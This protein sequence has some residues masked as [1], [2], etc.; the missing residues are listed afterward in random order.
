MQFSNG[1]SNPAGL[2]LGHLMFDSI[3]ATVAA[4]ILVIVFAATSTLFHGLGF[5]VSSL[6]EYAKRETMLMSP[7]WFIMVLYGFTGTL[8][9]Y[10]FSVVITSPLAAGVIR[11]P[12]PGC[13]CWS[14]WGANP[15]VR[16]STPEQAAATRKLVLDA[17]HSAM[18]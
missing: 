5:L 12:E 9:A 11:C 15:D 10:C 4:T 7:Q 17:L 2:W 3:I 1:L 8:F 13:D 18:N 16:R 14:T 6:S